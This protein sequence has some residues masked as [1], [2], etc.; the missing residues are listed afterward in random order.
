MELAHKQQIP[1]LGI[2]PKEMKSSLPYKTICT[3]TFIAALSPIT[4]T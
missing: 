2:Y 1:L 4:K 3:A